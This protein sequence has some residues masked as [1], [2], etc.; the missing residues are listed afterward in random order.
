MFTFY[1]KLNNVL[2]VVKLYSNRY[3]II[4]ETKFATLL[5]ALYILLCKTAKFKIVKRITLYY[6]L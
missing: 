4:Y 1:S 3:S 2:I 5:D 6:E